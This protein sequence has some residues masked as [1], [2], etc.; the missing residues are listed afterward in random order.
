[1][2]EKG[3]IGA[4]ERAIQKGWR[5]ALLCNVTT[6]IGL[7]TLVSSQLVP[8]KKFGLYSA[9]GVMLMLGVLLVYL[10]AALQI[11]PQ[12]PRLKRDNLPAEPSWWDNPKIS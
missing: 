9:I 5:P 7:I 2:R 3:H 6:A 8:I 1:V 11:W 10:P 4:P 12:K